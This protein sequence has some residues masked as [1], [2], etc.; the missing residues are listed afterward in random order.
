MA[1]LILCADD[2]AMRAEVDSAILQLICAGKLN[3]TACMVLSP[4][5]PQAA[6]SIQRE[7]RQQASIGLHLDFTEF[8][9]SYSLAKLILAC[10]SRRIDQSWVMA[11]IQAQFDAFEAALGTAPD[12][13][14]GHQ[15]IHQLPVIREALVAEMCRRYGKQLPWLRI[16]QTPAS[17]SFKANIINWLGA[18]ALKRLA[19]QANIPTTPILLGV[20]DFD[21]ARDDYRHAFQHWLQQAAQY[22]I[23]ALMCHPAT[24]QAATQDEIATARYAEYQALMGMDVAQMAKQYGVTLA[25]TPLS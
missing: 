4:R 9:S 16:A 14:D 18:G 11:R 10:I 8:N 23:S 15:H 13:I 6:K 17:W 12:Y 22:P 25:R 21:L 7:I 24:N 20:Y 1:K 5:W 19:Q 3:A 2:F